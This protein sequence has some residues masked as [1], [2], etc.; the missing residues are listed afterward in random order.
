MEWRGGGEEDVIVGSEK[1][2]EERRA[3]EL[4][5]DVLVLRDEKIWS[6]LRN[7]VPRCRF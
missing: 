4:R 2:S 5:E 1:E 7:I 3:E 6:T